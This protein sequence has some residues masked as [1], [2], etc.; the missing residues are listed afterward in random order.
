MQLQALWAR[1]VCSNSSR[2]KSGSQYGSLARIEK[3][4]VP[5]K[6][7]Y[8]QFQP[9]DHDISPEIQTTDIGLELY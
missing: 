4:L 6:K 5:Y 1:R 7:R 2:S 9:R 8:L 3:Y